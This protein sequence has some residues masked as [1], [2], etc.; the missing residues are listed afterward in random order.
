MVEE[1]ETAERNFERK[2]SLSFGVVCERQHLEQVLF[3]EL[4]SV[5]KQIAV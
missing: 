4:Q 2:G 1:E 3:A 5:K